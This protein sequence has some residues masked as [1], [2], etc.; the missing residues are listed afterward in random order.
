MS[1]AILF[2]S[3]V[4]PTAEDAVK[5]YVDLKADAIDLSQEFRKIAGGIFSADESA[6]IRNGSRE[7]QREELKRLA[8]EINEKRKQS[9][10]I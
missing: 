5:Q 7:M 6:R 4:D 8:D 2:P 3:A 9:N 1:S 10:Y